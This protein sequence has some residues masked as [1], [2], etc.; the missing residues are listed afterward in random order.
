MRLP[1]KFGIARVM[2]KPFSPRELL[3]TVQETLAKKR[4]DR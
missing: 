1:R 4:R 2:N 3:L